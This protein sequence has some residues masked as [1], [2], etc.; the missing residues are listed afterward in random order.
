MARQPGPPKMYECELSLNDGGHVEGFLRADLD[1]TA[2]YAVIGARE[3]GVSG[4]E[5]VTL[6]PE[7][8]AIYR[9]EDVARAIIKGLAPDLG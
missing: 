9:V 2:A 1:S 4:K 3:F 7:D 6:S 5:L 8:V